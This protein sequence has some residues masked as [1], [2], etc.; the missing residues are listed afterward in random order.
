MIGGGAAD[1]GVECGTGGLERYSEWIIGIVD[2]SLG[3]RGESN[4]VS[5][6]RYMR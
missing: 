4:V 2:M 6:L 3:L 5:C 1:P